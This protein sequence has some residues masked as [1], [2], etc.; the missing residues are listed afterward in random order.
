MATD[1]LADPGPNAPHSS[2]KSSGRLRKF[3]IY[4]SILFSLG[5]II[6][7]AVNIRAQT[8]RGHGYGLAVEMPWVCIAASLVVLGLLFVIH[9]RPNLPPR[10]RWTILSLIVLLWLVAFLVNTGTM[11]TRK[12]PSSIVSP[13]GLTVASVEPAP[14]HPDPAPAEPEPANPDSDTNQPTDL[15]SGDDWT[16]PATESVKAAIEV[17]KA[18]E[19]ALWILTLLA[20][21]FTSAMMFWDMYAVRKAGGS[22]KPEAL[23][24]EENRPHGQDYLDTIPDSFGP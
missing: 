10:S 9:R 3:F 22:A 6:A 24:A 23:P 16:E 21:L 4:I 8:N 17:A 5:V 14:V 15:D 2:L 12:T 7:A 13:R 19:D 1:G 20:L 18:S 11:A